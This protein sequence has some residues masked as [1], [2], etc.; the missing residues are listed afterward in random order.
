VRGT[1]QFYPDVVWLN[2]S[3]LLSERK[4]HFW[5]SINFAAGQPRD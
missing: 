2:G 4:D 1:C 5:R 3:R